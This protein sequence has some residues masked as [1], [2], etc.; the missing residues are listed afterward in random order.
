MLD[1]INGETE[2]QC[3][4]SPSGKG[5]AEVGGIPAASPCRATTPVLEQVTLALSPLPWDHKG[6]VAQG[7]GSRQEKPTRVVSRTATRCQP[8]L[9]LRAWGAQHRDRHQLKPG[10]EAPEVASCH[11]SG[12]H[13]I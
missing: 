13:G 4:T 1:T 7:Q 9:Q 6:C 10:D 3:V 8:A 5:Q 12:R 2:A 11:P